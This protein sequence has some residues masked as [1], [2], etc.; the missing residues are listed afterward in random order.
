M[1]KIT[2][3]CNELQFQEYLLANR[4]MIGAS[5]KSAKSKEK[6]KSFTVNR[7]MGEIV[8]RN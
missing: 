7:F 8:C 1:E 5:W 2:I 6:K 4:T 3:Y